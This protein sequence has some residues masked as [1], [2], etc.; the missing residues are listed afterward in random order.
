MKITISKLVITLLI[1]HFVIDITSEF[2]HLYNIESNIRTFAMISFSFIFF[3]SVLY[4]LKKD[5]LTMFSESYLFLIFAF[6]SFVIGI[7]L[8][9]FNMNFLSHTFT[10]VMPIFV[11]SLGYNI[12]N[13]LSTKDN[14]KLIYKCMNFIYYYSIITVLFFRIAVSK[15]IMSYGAIEAFGLFTATVYFIYNK[16][17]VKAFIGLTFIAI[18]GKRFLILITITVVLYYMLMLIKKNKKYLFSAVILSTLTILFFTYLYVKT[19][20]LDRFKLILKFNFSDMD[21]MLVATGGR[22]REVL[23]IINYLNENI[24]L[25]IFGGGFGSTVK[26]TDG[27]YRHFSHFTPIGYTLVYGIIFTILIYYFFVKEIFFKNNISQYNNNNLYWFKL[28]FVGL[29]VSTFFNSPSFFDSKFWF[30]YGIV[31]YYNSNIDNQM[32]FIKHDEKQ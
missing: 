28:V 10:F 2:Y 26:I 19:N 16:S 5:K 20:I 18:A 15:G 30:F 24:F 23:Q 11:M 1:A 21:S 9:N 17:F 29:F 27:L 14:S 25:W 32:K 8:N 6:I 7:L 22:S 31:K 3:I 12:A 13:Q 4:A